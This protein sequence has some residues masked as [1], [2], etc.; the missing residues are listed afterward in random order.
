MDKLRS[1]E[2]FVAV[3]DTGSF[4]AAARR[5][6]ISPVMV[7]KHVEFL[8]QTL[9][10]RL[11][12]RTTRRQSLT[13]IGERYCE[14]CRIVLAQVAA[15]ES[16]AEAM[17][18]APR[19]TLR[20]TAGVS[21]GG[22]LLS[23]VLADYLER[24]PEVSVMLDLSDRVVDIVEDGFDAAIR[25]GTL[26]DSGLVARPLWDY[27]MTIAA[28]PAYL[29]RFG[30]PRVPADLL[31]HRCLDFTHWNK[32][33]R[34]RLRGGEDLAIPV[35]R[36]RSNNGRALKNAALAGFGIIMQAE[37]ML[38]NELARGELVPLLQEHV[39]EPRPMHLLYPRDLQP[40]PKLTT[41][42][43]FMLERFGKTQRS[44]AAV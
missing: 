19:G 31:R 9:G 38:A 13:E 32:Q 6:D 36:F 30:T 4:T 44:V 16:G 8:E 29:E 2:V 25:I 22:E 1:M 14:Q 15:A 34:W 33:L 12:A 42:I 23:P 43:D 28:S 40:T 11:L 37:M 20:I 41:F 35:S 18:T 3:V 39:P 5:F 21:F 7:G 27:G 24:Y 17:R 26:D 10:A